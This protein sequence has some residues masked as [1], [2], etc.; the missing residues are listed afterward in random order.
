MTVPPISLSL[1]TKADEIV[2]A[3][4]AA[5]R[6]NE[7]A[8]KGRKSREEVEVWA[9]YL[10]DSIPELLVLL[11]RR[12]YPGAVLLN[13]STPAPRRLFR[14]QSPP[15][16]MAAWVLDEE[17]WSEGHSSVHLLSDGR[18]VSTGWSS[19]SPWNSGPISVDEISTKYSD[20][21]ARNLLQKTA[22]GVER[23]IARYGD[24]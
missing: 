23:L 12:D 13:I 14:R 11:E 20:E 16:E 1:V 24:Q 2:K 5:Q 3:R 7:A 15:T 8:R 22:K 19:Q 10:A 18:L 21:G 9:Q 6:A 17:R 4:L